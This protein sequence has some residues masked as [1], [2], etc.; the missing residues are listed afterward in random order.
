VAPAAVESQECLVGGGPGSGQVP[1]AVFPF[2]G[3]FYPGKAGQR[4]GSGHESA[5]RNSGI[6]K[7]AASPEEPRQLNRRQ[8]DVRI[9]AVDGSAGDLET[10][11]R[12]VNTT[13][14][15]EQTG[16]PHQISR[17]RPAANLA[18]AVASIEVRQ[19]SP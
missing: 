7:A 2:L 8:G 17:R 18:L 14:V 15:T 12:F 1:F 11:D 4:P 3:K 10:S 9:A 5:P 6:G 19:D 13:F 16:Q